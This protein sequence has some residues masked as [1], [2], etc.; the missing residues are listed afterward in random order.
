MQNKCGGLEHGN[1]LYNLWWVPPQPATL[2][3]HR[4]CCYLH[5]WRFLCTKGGRFF[6]KT[7]G[8]SEQKYFYFQSKPKPNIGVFVNFSRSRKPNLVI[9]LNLRSQFHQSNP[10]PKTN[11][12]SQESLT[13]NP[14]KSRS[15]FPSSDS[16]TAPTAVA[17]ELLDYLTPPTYTLKLGQHE[18]RVWKEETGKAPPS[19]HITTEVYKYCLH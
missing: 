13:K 6:A 10:N 16:L 1:I 15:D 3:L 9:F 11:V 18:Q 14:I 17:A 7:S 5:N 8:V 2:W 4:V 12:L 19:V